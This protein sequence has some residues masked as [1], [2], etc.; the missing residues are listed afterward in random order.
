MQIDA[1]IFLS[2]Y[3]SKFTAK[4]F[5]TVFFISF[6]SLYIHLFLFL[7]LLYP[8]L[9]L[10]TNLLIHIDAYLFRSFFQSKFTAILCYLSLFFVYPP[11]FFPSLVYPPL[12]FYTSLSMQIDA[13]IFLS[14]NRSKFTAKSFKTVSLSHSI[15]CI[16]TCFCFHLLSIPLFFF[17]PLYQSTLIPIS[18]YLILSLYQS[19]FTATFFNAVFFISVYSLHIH[20]YFIPL[21]SI[22]LYF[23]IP[24]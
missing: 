13:Y 2:L 1:Y 20:I 19:K 6:Y 4:S 9:F 21:L 8:P 5:K 24:V 15:L 11:I 22:H 18:F 16:S 7:S 12:F 14:L 3:R 23:F 17:I 10:Y